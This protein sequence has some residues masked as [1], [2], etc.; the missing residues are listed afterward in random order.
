VAPERGT[1]GNCLPPGRLRDLTHDCHAGGRGFDSR[2]PRQHLA[3]FQYVGAPRDFSDMPGGASDTDGTAR[4]PSENGYGTYSLSTERLTTA[5]CC[6]QVTPSDDL[7]VPRRERERGTTRS[8]RSVPP[9]VPPSSQIRRRNQGRKSGSSKGARWSRLERPDPPAVHVICDG[10]GAPLAVHMTGANRHDS[11]E[12]LPLVDAI[13]PLQ[14]ERGRP[15]CR[16][17]CAGRASNAARQWLG[18]LTL[19]SGTD[20]CVAESVLPPARPLR[21][22][23]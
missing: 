22:T 18:T 12:A 6:S 15:H 23:D 20:V 8:D 11:K 3:Y 1:L 21:E 10:Q 14:G 13:P 17:D 4:R 7:C 16:P 9:F 5:S 19:G 2:R